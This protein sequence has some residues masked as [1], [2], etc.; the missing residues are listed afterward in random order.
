M[1]RIFV[2]AT[3]RDKNLTVHDANVAFSY[4]K[5]QNHGS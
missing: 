4:K 1:T 5:T 2:F 3:V